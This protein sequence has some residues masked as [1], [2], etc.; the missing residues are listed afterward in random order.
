MDEQIYACT[1]CEYRSHKWF[2][3]CPSCGAWSS[4]AQGVGAALRVS[5][6][7][8]SPEGGE[9]SETGIGEVDR[10][11]GGGLV[12]GAAVLLSGEPGIGKSTLVLQL[13]DAL[14]RGGRS[15][16][17]VTG[18][19]S[20]DQVALR[21]RRLGVDSSLIDAAASTSLPAI[22]A[23]CTALAPDVLVVDSIQTLVDPQIDG[24][25]GGVAQV[26]ACAASLVA[27]AKSSGTV[28]VLI[29]H[30]TKDG[31]VAGPKTLE[32]IVDVV[33]TLE[34]ERSG[35]VR[36]LRA[37]KN[38]FGSCEETGVFVM[39]VRGL[40][41]VPDPSEMLLADR[42]C[43][44]P[45]S[46]VFPGLEG[47][48]PLLVE[49]QGL[50][51]DPAFGQP[52]QVAIGVEAR[53]VS[54]LLGII[55]E[56]LDV[57]LLK[58]DVFVAAAGGIAVREPAADLALSLALLSAISAV[59]LDPSIVALGEVGLAGEIRRVPGIDRRL[60]EAKRMGFTKAL[61]P[62]GVSARDGIEV[63]TAPD[64]RTVLEVVQGAPRGSSAGPQNARR[65]TLGAAPAAEI[66]S[67]P[68]RV[69]AP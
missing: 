65:A 48:R 17:L 49:L 18:E 6:L 10:V 19:E 12:R 53:R 7:D 47:S 68:A 36:L 31:S 28:V 39:G 38:R 44:V 41:A 46:V 54:L 1:S 45:G 26:K 42:S 4:A 69:A 8:R 61:V 55:S 50:V 35:A 40:E 62:R 32:H 11:L 67:P 52:R 59:P 15:T 63:L 57:P 33:L 27:L 21:G 58:Q 43:G 14:V 51:T 9:R 20:V 5:R 3:R 66:P 34:G 29:G 60:S 22:E 2:G 16:L 24:A 56:R 13:I 64:L 30:V 23:A 37:S 25:P